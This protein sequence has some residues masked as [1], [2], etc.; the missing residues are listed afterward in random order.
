[1]PG[2]TVWTP[3]DRHGRGAM[4]SFFRTDVSHKMDYPTCRLDPFWTLYRGD[5]HPQNQHVGGGLHG[6]VFDP[7][8][9]MGLSIRPGAMGFSGFRPG[10][11][12]RAGANGR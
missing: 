5:Q 8:V 3:A 4:G 7:V 9:C 6:V 12:E 11:V 2:A 1:M 10:R